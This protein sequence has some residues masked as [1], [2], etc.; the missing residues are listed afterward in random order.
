M[1]IVIRYSRDAQTLSS[2]RVT[3]ETHPP[4]PELLILRVQV[5]HFLVRIQEA[6][7]VGNS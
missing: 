4:P 3:Q 2:I 6:T 7:G 5:W 1:N